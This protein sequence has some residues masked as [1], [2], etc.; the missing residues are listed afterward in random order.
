MGLFTAGISNISDV[1]TLELKPEAGSQA[2]NKAEG[3]K[4]E[5]V[6]SIEVSCSLCPKEV[7][8]RLGTCADGTAGT[9]IWRPLGDLLEISGI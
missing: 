5:E 1:L 7:D 9:R 2:L 6:I 4:R 3:F 8:I